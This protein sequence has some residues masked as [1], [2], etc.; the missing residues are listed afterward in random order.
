MIYQRR[1]GGT[2]KSIVESDQ[3]T[4]G[5]DL[6]E[7]GGRDTEVYSREGPEGL[8]CPR[9]EGG[10][11]K[12]IVQRDQRREGIRRREGSVCCFMLSYHSLCQ[13]RE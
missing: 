4:R 5:F 13:V 9:R 2:L 1:E 6:S 12:S 8:L 11:L 10:T 7:E 3:E